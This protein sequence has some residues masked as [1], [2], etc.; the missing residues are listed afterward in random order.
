MRIIITRVRD[1]NDETARV[2]IDDH[3][4]TPSF[5]FNDPF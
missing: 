4:F 1:V 3:V 5:P 2:P